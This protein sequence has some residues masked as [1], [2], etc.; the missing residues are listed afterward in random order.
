M[1]ESNITIKC[2]SS[3]VARASGQRVRTDLSANLE[4]LQCMDTSDILTGKTHPAKGDEPNSTESGR[5][6]RDEWEVR[7]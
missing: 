2:G 3:V 6:K 1:E 7:G 5:G 4:L